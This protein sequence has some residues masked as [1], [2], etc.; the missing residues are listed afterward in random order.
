MLLVIWTINFLFLMTISF[1]LS[2]LF[3]SKNVN[4]HKVLHFGMIF[5]PN[6]KYL[7]RRC[8]DTCINFMKTFKKHLKCITILFCSR[9]TRLSKWKQLSLILY[10]ITDAI[11]ALSCIN[12][13]FLIFMIHNSQNYA[14]NYVFRLLI[15]KMLAFYSNGNLSGLMRKIIIDWSRFVSLLEDREGR[16]TT[17]L[18]LFAW[19]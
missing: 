10:L 16:Q 17:S 1:V 12:V 11:Y 8:E 5:A 13:C 3:F 19:S 15:C 7:F 9:L 6:E 14:H 4:S 18:I 2:L